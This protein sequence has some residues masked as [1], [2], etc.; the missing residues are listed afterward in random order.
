ME[1]PIQRN[2][3][4]HPSLTQHKG[5]PAHM[6]I[7]LTGAFGNLGMSTLHELLRQGHQVRCFVTRRNA[8]LLTARQFTGK[9]ELF[10]SDLLQPA[11]HDAA[12]RDQDVI[13]HTAYI[14]P[15]VSEDRPDFARAINVEGTRNLL[16]AACKQP[17]PPKFLFVSTFQVFGTTQHLPP[18]RKVTDPMHAIDHYSTHKIACEEMV[19]ASGLDWSIY[20]FCDIVPLALRKPHP[21]MYK[22][23]LSTRFELVHTY[24]AGL[25]IANGMRNEQIWGKILLI[26]GGPSCQITYQEYLSRMLNM[27]GLGMLPESAFATKPYF[28]DWLDTEE[29]QR[30]LD[31]QR[32]SFDDIVQHLTRIFGHQK[33]LVS[34][35]RPIARW[36]VLRLSP[37]YHHQNFAERSFIGDLPASFVESD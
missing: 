6:K 29:S 13:I 5:A 26:G 20:R 19:R 3:S 22:I 31:Y 7:L 24:D 4:N 27:M 28:A 32:Y 37:Y 10:R 34:L 12:V 8:H 2:H 35:V 16:A 18:P 30:L 17:R 25:A 9:I 11:E 21:I 36:W 33:Q 1:E 15:P 14:I 23:P